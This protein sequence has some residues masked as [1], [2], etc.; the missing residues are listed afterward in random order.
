MP[1][2]FAD[3]FVLLWLGY[4]LAAFASRFSVVQRR[5]KAEG[6]RS[7]EEL[8]PKVGDGVNR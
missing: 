6:E 3:L 1:P 5:P 8:W 2:R 7:D 4:A